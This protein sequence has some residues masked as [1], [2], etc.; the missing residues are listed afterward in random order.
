MKQYEDELYEDWLEGV[1][2]TLPGLL[3]K[4]VLT[5]PSAIPLTATSSHSLHNMDS[6]SG[7]RPHSRTD[8]SYIFPPGNLV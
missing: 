3:K 2:A 5:K 1:S 4:T 7:S 8:Y 6:R